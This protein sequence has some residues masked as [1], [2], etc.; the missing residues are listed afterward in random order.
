MH[1]LLLLGAGKIGRGFLADLFH[2]ANYDL[3]LIDQSQELVDLLQEAG[4]YRVVRAT[5]PWRLDPEAT[6]PP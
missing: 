4:S 2:A 3:V 6:P 5:G 1:R